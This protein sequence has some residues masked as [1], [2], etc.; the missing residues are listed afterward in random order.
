MQ[1]VL[2]L[3]K[4]IENLDKKNPHAVI[5]GGGFIGLELLE[6]FLERQ[7]KVTI[8]EKTEQLLP[9]FDTQIIEYL[10]NYLPDRGVRLLTGEQVAGVATK[11]DKI[12]S[13]DTVSGKKLPADLVFMGIGT[14]PEVGLA[15]Q[16]GIALGNSGAVAVNKYMQTNV[17]DV[18]AAGDCCECLNEIT[19]QWHPIIWPP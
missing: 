5:V 7:M 10:H 8:V 11:E 17:A 3:K 2:R 19:E 6:A 14:R 16:A 12:I 18:Y 1:T 13:V 15:K 4:Y 9:M